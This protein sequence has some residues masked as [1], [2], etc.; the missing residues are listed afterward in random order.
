MVSQEKA[1]GG[2]RDG[3]KAKSKTA[4]SPTKPSPQLPQQPSHLPSYLPTSPEI[5]RLITPD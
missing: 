5:E 2:N 3:Q 4:L 1:V